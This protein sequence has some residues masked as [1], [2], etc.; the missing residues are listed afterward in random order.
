MILKYPVTL[1]WV[2]RDTPENPPEKK[3]AVED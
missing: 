3:G 1:V 2:I